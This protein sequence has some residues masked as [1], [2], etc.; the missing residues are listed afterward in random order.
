MDW[1]RSFFQGADKL[2][3]AAKGR[4]L[5]RNL[6]GY[7]TDRT[8]DVELGLGPSSIGCFG[9]FYAQSIK[10]LPEYY[11]ALDAGKFPILRGYRLTDDDIIRRDVILRIIC[12]GYVSKKEIEQQHKIAFDD[13]FAVEL[14]SLK[15]YID[16]GLVEVTAE[17]V[18]VHPVG[19]FFVQHIA[20][21]F[22]VSA[23]QA[24]VMCA[25]RR[26]RNI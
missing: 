16:D 19:R 17:A 22:D 2:A 14:A 6:N 24:R 21:E 20:R 10:T 26:S 9:R 7:T 13:Y 8:Y 18:N 4:T 5:G 15:N 3:K 23:R 11:Q 1:D 12:N 25:M